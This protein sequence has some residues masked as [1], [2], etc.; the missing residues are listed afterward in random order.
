M[1]FWKKNSVAFFKR[2]GEKKINCVLMCNLTN[3][4]I[5][6]EKPQ[7]FQYQQKKKYNL[8]L[9]LEFFK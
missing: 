7:N 2:I 9:Y 6:L 4:A 8:N 1:I 5:L 3:S